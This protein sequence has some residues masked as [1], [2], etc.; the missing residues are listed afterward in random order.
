MSADLWKQAASR[1]PD[2][3]STSE[4]AAYLEQPENAPERVA[5]NEHRKTCS[6]CEAELVMLAAFLQA[7]PSLEEA[8]D[9]AYIGARLS[10]AASPSPA[11]S[12][13]KKLFA[14]N[15]FRVW[16]FAAVALAAVAVGI[17]YRSGTLPP[18]ARESGGVM[19]ATPFITGLSPTGDVAEPP[20][21]FSW[22]PVSG[23][24]SYQFTILAVD[25][26]ELYRCPST[27]QPTCSP[28]P[29]QDVFLP[30]RTVQLRVT[31]LD[32]SGKQIAVSPDMPLRV[33]P[34][35]VR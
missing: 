10:H 4:W 27:P 19:R 29:P 15:T 34:Q 24:A 12:W 28:A 6:A 20:K 18:V 8:A 17:Q 9:L 25:G 32:Q 14:P 13:W 23:A 5:L 3:P 26:T 21:Q 33:L 35:A 11:A 1:R 2:C 31:A 22:Q 30:L 7:Q 16:A